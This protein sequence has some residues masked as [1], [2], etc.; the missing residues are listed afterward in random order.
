MARTATAARRPHAPRTPGDEPEDLLTTVEAA[1][2]L[3]FSPR[4][5]ERYRVTGEGPEY[6][7]LGRRV[8]YHREKLDEWIELK[9]RRS[10]SDPGPPNGP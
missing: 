6:L 2:S 10:T 5:L 1:R 8:F 3:R 7:K 9:W 4:T